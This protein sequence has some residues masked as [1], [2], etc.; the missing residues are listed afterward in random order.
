MQQ[1]LIHF[2]EIRNN[3]IKSIFLFILFLILIIGLGAI[4][5]LVW[6]DLYFGLIIAGIFALAYSLIA[7]YSGKNMLMS[8][9]NA[10]EV[11]KKDEPYLYHTIEGLAIAAN[12]PT[13]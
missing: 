9:A 2:D 1:K 7:Y 8:L 11:T 3:N 10:K 6:G 12:I 4:I 13:P 5:G